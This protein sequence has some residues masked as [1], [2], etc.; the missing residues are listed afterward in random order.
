MTGTHRQG[1][2]HDTI[3]LSDPAVGD[4]AAEQRREIDETGVE[5]ENLRRER[6]RRERA[7]E[8]FQSGP[9]ARKSGDVLDMARQQQ[10]VDHVQD[11]QRRHSVIGKAFPGFGAGMIGPRVAGGRAG[12]AR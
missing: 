2:D 8:R 3:A 11:D 9:E 4:D 1:A 7:D 12:R 6:L 5:T 10:L